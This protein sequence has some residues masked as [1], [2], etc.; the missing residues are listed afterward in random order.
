[1]IRKDE[2]MRSEMLEKPMG[3]LLFEKSYPTVI[4]Q[5]ISVIYNTAD[6]YFVAKI[7]TESAAAVG[8]VFSLMS[9]IQA[10]G[11]GI[12]MGASSLISRSLGAQDSKRANIYGST[13]VFSGI[14]FGTLLMIVG[15]I[16]SNRFMRLIGASE[17]VL[18]YA[19]SYARYILIAAPFM[20][21]AFVLNNILKAEGQSFISMIAMIIGGFLNMLLDPLL[22]F[23][24]QLGIRGAAIATMVSQIISAIVM[25]RYF[26]KKRSIVQLSFKNIS[27]EASIYLT[28]IKNGTPTICRQGL[29]SLSSAI[30]NIQASVYGD[31]AVAAISIANKIYMLIRNIVLGIGQGYQPI[32]GYCYG[33]GKRER[34]KKAFVLSSI[35][36]TLICSIFAVLVYLYK[37]PIM[38][39]FRADE[40]VVA[41]GTNALNWFCIAMP[42]LAYSTYVNQTYQCLGYSGPATLLASC[43]QGIFFIPL[44][45][46]LPDRIGITGIEMLQSTADVMT[47]LISVPFQIW[48]FKRHLISEKGN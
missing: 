35:A 3:R 2:V 41:I 5:L 23:K 6:T 18:P 27:K 42:L 30:L 14:V 21:L 15:L 13:A 22:I 24:L 9:I 12:G 29:G 36:G 32:A 44:A 38:T 1:M 43:R 28:I 25:Y 4:I 31:T 26:A 37:I 7:N 8:V 34:V 17:T 39:W 11:F 16:N 20:C 33:A 48:F 19:V 40:D 46:I 45:F 47:F 10:V